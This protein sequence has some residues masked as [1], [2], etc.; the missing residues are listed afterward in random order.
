MNARS[1]SHRLSVIAIAFAGLAASSTPLPAYPEFRAFVVQ[2]SGRPV[3]C[4]MCHVNR[5]GPEGAGTG[6]IG[7]LSP[8][9]LEQLERARAAF[10]PGSK[11]ENPILNAF[12][13]HLVQNLGLTKIRELRL[14]PAQLAEGLPNDSDLDGDGIPDRQEYLDGTNSVDPRDGRPWLLFKH[15]FRRHWAE[16]LLALTATM[17]GL[18]GLSHLLHGFARASRAM[19]EPESASTLQPG[20]SELS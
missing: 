1:S 11:A 10:A 6:Q 13:N 7:R 17:A 16:I 8:A 2:H 14:V 12:G 9:E 19:P 5:D 15:N 20:V 3:D 18:Y 4:A